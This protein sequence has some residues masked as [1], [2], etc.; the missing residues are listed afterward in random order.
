MFEYTPDA[1]HSG[2]GFYYVIYIYVYI[3]EPI[4][5]LG[6][7]FDIYFLYTLLKDTG[8][9]SFVLVAPF[10]PKRRGAG[11]FPLAYACA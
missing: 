3:Y 11:P 6:T 1:I 4:T 5:Q 10:T 8:P 2:R 9:R 7:R